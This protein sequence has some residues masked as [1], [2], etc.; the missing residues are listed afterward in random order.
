MFPPLLPLLGKSVKWQ[1]YN[2]QM[3]NTTLKEQR[4][5]PSVCAWVT[6]SFR[7]AQGWWGGHYLRSCSCSAAWNAERSSSLYILATLKKLDLPWVGKGWSLCIMEGRKTNSTGGFPPSISVIR[8]TPEEAAQEAIALWQVMC[9]ICRFSPWHVQLKGSGERWWGEK[10]SFC[11]PRECLPGAKGWA[12]ISICGSLSFSLKQ[13]CTSVC[14]KIHLRFSSNFFQYLH[15][16]HAVLP[17]L[18]IFAKTISPMECTS[19]CCPQ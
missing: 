3:I 12:S 9:F 14:V 7:R 18:H 4:D 8:A 2:W 17:N 16:L 19:L 13:P 5:L 15:F 6:A 10:T 11:N 1:L